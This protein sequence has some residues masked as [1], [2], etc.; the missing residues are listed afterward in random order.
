ME[1]ATTLS[2][3]YA[4]ISQDSGLVAFAATPPTG[5]AEVLVGYLDEPTSSFGQASPLS[6]LV[7]ISNLS[8]LAAFAGVQMVQ[9]QISRIPNS[10]AT[11]VSSLPVM[12]T[13]TVSMAS[14][15]T[16]TFN[17][18]LDEGALIT[19][20]PV[21]SSSPDGSQ[22]NNNQS[23]SLVTVDGTWTTGAID[24]T[25]NPPFDPD[26]LRDSHLPGGYSP[27]GVQNRAVKGHE[28]GLRLS[29][30]DRTALIAFLKTL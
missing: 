19:L 30:A 7:S 22:L 15:L 24:T 4:A 16:V 29:N 23:G 11:A 21:P 8:S 2:S 10:G 20:Q 27:P 25:Y 28:F 13:Y 17:I 6:T 1:Y 14:P 9:V 5:G 26:R 12:N 3:R 18:N